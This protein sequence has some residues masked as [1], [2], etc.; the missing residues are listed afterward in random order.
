MIFLPLYFSHLFLPAIFYR[1]NLASGHSAYF[2]IIIKAVIAMNKLN[3]GSP[4]FETFGEKETLLIVNWY[5]RINVDSSFPAKEWLHPNLEFLMYGI[6]LD[7]MF[8]IRL[9]RISPW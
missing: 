9:E 6:D 4:K 5:T 7:G 8:I 1:Q 2:G 3:L